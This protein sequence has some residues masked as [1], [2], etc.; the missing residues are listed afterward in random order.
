MKISDISSQRQLSELDAAQ[1]GQSAGSGVRT[2]GANVGGFAKGFAQGLMG[3]KPNPSA[4]SA[5]STNANTKPNAGAKTT[6]GTGQGSLDTIK[7]AISKLS[8]KQ[9]AA[10]RTQI[11]QK[12]GVK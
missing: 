8:P 10:I 11:A 4:G 12:A 5:P 9:R 6:A 3:K 7:D 2:I 1:M